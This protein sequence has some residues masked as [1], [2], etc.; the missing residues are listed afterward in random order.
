MC[1]VTMTT[2]FGWITAAVQMGF[3]TGITLL[4]VKSENYLPHTSFE[5][6]VST[7]ESR[8][9]SG[10][11]IRWDQRGNGCLNWTNQIK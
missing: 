7:G 8:R 5:K 1:S 2:A 3:S 9:V 10:V 11:T 6:L 4:N